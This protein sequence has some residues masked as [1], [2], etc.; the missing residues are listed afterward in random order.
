MKRKK[1]KNID[2]TET[3]AVDKKAETITIMVIVIFALLGLI[4]GYVMYQEFSGED[5]FENE[6][7]NKIE[8]EY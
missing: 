6:P 5:Q 1:I 7:I 2:R 8:N 3:G 4:F